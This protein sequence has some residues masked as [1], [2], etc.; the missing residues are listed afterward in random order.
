[1][2]PPMLGEDGESSGASSPEPDDPQERMPSPTL[3]EPLSAPEVPQLVSGL[4]SM[5]L[6][7]ADLSSHSVNPSVTHTDPAT[8]PSTDSLNFSSSLRSQYNSGN[9]LHAQ[10]NITPA[11]FP[12]YSS[13]SS[14]YTLDDMTHPSL[15]PL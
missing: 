14:S 9:E 1:M 4:S 8:P 5:E 3:T 13:S 15:Y 12:P 10:A 6:R 7:Q 11:N 2:Q